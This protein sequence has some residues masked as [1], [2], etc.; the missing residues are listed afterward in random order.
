MV[1]VEEEEE[2]VDPA[3]EFLSREQEQLGDI[4]KELEAVLTG[5]QSGFKNHFI[6]LYLSYCSFCCHPTNS[7]VYFNT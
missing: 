1:Q 3:A 4:D 6:F 7:I 5:D 2:E